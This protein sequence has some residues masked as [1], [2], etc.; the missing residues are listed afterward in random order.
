MD[1]TYSGEVSLS[2]FHQ[3]S[4]LKKSRIESGRSS[5][6]WGGVF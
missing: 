6:D 2:G 3:G 4:V 1:V 5:S